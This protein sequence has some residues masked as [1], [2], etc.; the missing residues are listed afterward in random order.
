GTRV[1]VDSDGSIKNIGIDSTNNLD[2]LRQQRYRMAME[3]SGWLQRRIDDEDDNIN[4]NDSLPNDIPSDNIPEDVADDIPRDEADIP[5]ES[6]V[7]PTSVRSQDVNGNSGE[8]IDNSMVVRGDI[9]TYEDGTTAT[10]SRNVIK[11]HAGN[12]DIDFDILDDSGAHLDDNGDM[13]DLVASPEADDFGEFNDAEDHDVYSTP[14]ERAAVEG[15]TNNDTIPKKDIT[16]VPSSRPS[17]KG[18]SASLP[19]PLSTRRDELR[20]IIGTSTRHTFGKFITTAPMNDSI[21]MVIDEGYIGVARVVG[22]L[23]DENKVD[24]Q[25]MDVIQEGVLTKITDNNDK[26]TLDVEIGNL[27]YVRPS[28]RSMTRARGKELRDLLSYVGDFL[29]QQ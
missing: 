26:A 20:D 27:I 18:T 7:R 21:V 1:F 12:N 5:D 8:L 29:L 9:E 11:H 14:N 23:T 2:L 25:P 22:S 3:K 19:K 10:P 24:L 16:N 28:T 13:E 4:S 6:A 15:D 17:R